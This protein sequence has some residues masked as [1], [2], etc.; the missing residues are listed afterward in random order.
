[1]YG[2]QFLSWFQSSRATLGPA[3]GQTLRAKCPEFAPESLKHC[4]GAFVGFLLI[5]TREKLFRRFY[6]DNFCATE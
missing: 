5:L 1:M 3:D 4:N 6:I 2:V